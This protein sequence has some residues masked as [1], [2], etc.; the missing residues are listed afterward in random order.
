MVL[1]PL[2]LLVLVPALAER[3]PSRC[4]WLL[5]DWCNKAKHC[6]SPAV[7]KVALHDTNAVQGAAAWRCYPSSTLNTDRSAYVWSGR[8][9]QGI[10][11]RDSQLARLLETCMAAP[12][13]K[14]VPV[15]W[16]GQ[17]GHLC[18]RTPSLVTMANGTLLAFASTR[19]E[20]GDGCQPVGSDAHLGAEGYPAFVMRRSH[21]GGAS[22]DAIRTI[23]LG[24]QGSRKHARVHGTAVYDHARNRVIM[25]L[26]H[27]D[28][29]LKTMY[30]D[31]GGNSWSAPQAL[32]LQGY[33]HSSVGPGTGLQ[34][35]GRHPL[36]PHRVVFVNHFEGR[37]WGRHSGNVVY[38]SDDGGE[39]WN[40]SRTIVK[41]C[42]EAQVVELLDGS[43]LINA[44]LG[45]RK[46]AGARRF[47]RSRDGGVTW[48]R[49]WLQKDLKAAKAQGSFISM[50]GEDGR[51]GGVLLYAHTG[52]KFSSRHRKRAEGTVW[53]SSDQGATFHR[54]YAPNGEGGGEVGFSYSA[55]SDITAAAAG[56][57]PQASARGAKANVGLLYETHAQGCHGASCQVLFQSFTYPAP[58]PASKFLGWV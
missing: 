52:S 35:S 31:D 45:R 26:V 29:Q 17:D 55:L 58:K 11:T 43:L 39:S 6:K 2:V 32:D 46:F 42:N 27:A 10:C 48:R 1:A 4:S 47:A 54:A 14:G 53:A 23:H 38:F 25:S 37:A 5:D 21:D 56:A 7:D 19:T 44:R 34:L 12:E 40:V 33:N 15:F 13:P 51:P 28:G 20:A 16:H 41:H 22:W 24:A 9:D 49:S 3:P 30:S 36:A 50:A 57:V 8:P 18:T